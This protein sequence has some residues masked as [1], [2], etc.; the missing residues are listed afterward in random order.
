LVLV[1]SE[2]PYDVT[3]DDRIHATV[4]ARVGGAYGRPGIQSHGI[5]LAA[6]F[7]FDASLTA[8]A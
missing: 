8:R 7:R 5:K 4:A 3:G 1:W 2:R 6:G